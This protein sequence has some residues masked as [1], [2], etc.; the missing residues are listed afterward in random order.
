MNKQPALRKPRIKENLDKITF[1]R[2]GGL[3]SKS[4][5]SK[6]GIWPWGDKVD[7]RCEQSISNQIPYLGQSVVVWI[8]RLSTGG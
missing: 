1:L 3:V 4:S 7:G 2:P 8:S 6:Q 5:R